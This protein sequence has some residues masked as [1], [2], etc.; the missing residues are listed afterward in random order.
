[1]V[2]SEFNE[3]TREETGAVLDVV[4]IISSMYTNRN[5]TN[6]EVRM[7]KC[8]VSIIDLTKPCQNKNYLN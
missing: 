1:M 3:A 7:T 5:I 8:D 2:N 6:S 4:R